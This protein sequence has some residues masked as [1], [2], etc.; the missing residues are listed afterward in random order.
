MHLGIKRK[1]KKILIP[2]EKPCSGTQVLERDACDIAERD[3]IVAD[4]RPCR[5]NRHPESSGC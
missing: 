4:I 1:R 5:A 2:F 3:R